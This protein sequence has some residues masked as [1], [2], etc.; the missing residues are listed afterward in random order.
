MEGRVVGATDSPRSGSRLTGA[1]VFGP[2]AIDL[3]NDVTTVARWG[4]SIAASGL[5]DAPGGA[6]GVAPDRG[7]IA[8]AWRGDAARM[9]DANGFRGAR[10]SGDGP[11][12][13]ARGC[14]SSH[15]ARTR[16]K[17]GRLV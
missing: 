3:G 1:C 2:G 17:S 11:A 7:G 4:G 12:G 5:T 14:G 10:R 8:R 9:D 15:A 16:G 13:S 6:W